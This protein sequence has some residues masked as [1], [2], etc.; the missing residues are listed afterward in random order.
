MA[1]WMDRWSA[2]SEYV[3]EDDVIADAT[4]LNF[5]SLD[6]DTEGNP[7]RVAPEDTDDWSPE[8]YAS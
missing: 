6:L 2:P 4:V 5:T 7:E 3:E 1:R 8:D